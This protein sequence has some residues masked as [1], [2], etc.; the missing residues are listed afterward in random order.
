MTK[1][2]AE[3][4]YNSVGGFI[5][6]IF[7]D[8][9]SK[10]TKD[11]IGLVTD[12][13]SIAS[14]MTKRTLL[15]KFV[16]AVS[17]I[18]DMSV[19]YD[20]YTSETVT[21][22]KRTSDVLKLIS[23]AGALVI[24]F[25]PELGATELGLN[26]LGM[27]RNDVLLQSEGYK[28]ASDEK[29]DLKEMW[30]DFV[31]SMNDDADRDPYK[32]PERDP[33]KDPERDPYKDPERDPYKDPERDPYKDP[34]RDPHKD[35]GRDPHKDPE[36][37][38]YTPPWWWPFKP[39]DSEHVDPVVLNLKK[40]GGSRALEA[41]F[42][43]FDYDG[44]G[45]AE[46]TAWIGKNQGLL[47]IDRNGNETI[48]DGGELFGNQTILSNGRTAVDGYQ[49]LAELD[50]NH[51]GVIDATDAAWQDLRVWVD[52]GDGAT[53]E[54][55]LK[56]LDELGITSLS[57]QKS[58]ETSADS[59][60]NEKRLIGTFTWTDG[61]TG[62]MHDYLFAVDE[63][64]TYNKTS[65]AVSEEV[66][67]EFYLPGSG[68]LESSWQF[69]MKSEDDALQSLLHEYQAATDADATS[70][71]LD[72]ILYAMAGNTDDNAG[73]GSYMDARQLNVIEKFF[74]TKFNNGGNPNKWNGPL[75]ADLY[76]NIKRYY[77]GWLSAQTTAAEYISKI[78]L[79]LD[80]ETGKLCIDFT[81]VKSSLDEKITEDFEAGKA[82]LADFTN[83]I[84]AVGLSNLSE[85]DSMCQEFIA[86][87]DELAVAVYTTGRNII[88][89]TDGNDT[90]HDNSSNSIILGGV[91]NDKLTA[92]GSDVML[93]GGK[94]N[95]ELHGSRGD[96]PNDW[97]DTAGTGTVSYVWNAGDGNDTIINVSNLERAQ[98]T[99]GKSYLRYGVG[100][101][102]ESLEFIRDKDNIRI[103]Y[104]KTGEAI[105]IRNW[106]KDVAYKLTGI[107]FADG[108]YMDSKTLYE[109]ASAFPTTEGNDTL[110]GSS[111]A[112]TLDGGAGDDY[113]EGWYGD[114]VY[115]W[116]MGSGNDTIHN[117]AKS[118]WGNYVEMGADVLHVKDISKEEM[119]WKV[120][121]NNLIGTIMQTNERVVLENW[122]ANKV[123]RLDYVIFDDGT[124]LTNDE[125]DAMAQISNGTEEADTIRGGDTLDDIIYGK[126]GNDRLYGNSGNDTL[127]GGAGD[128]Y[129]EGWYGDDVY[130]WG[131]G[132]G[133][134]TIHN[135]AKNG[136]GDY[137]DMGADVL[138]VKDISKEEMSWKV[139]GNNLIGTIMQTNERVVLENWYANKVNR[140]DY[141]IFDD[142]TILTNDEIDAMAQISNGTEEADT[143]RGGDTL[144]D[145][146][147]GKS[148]NDRLY[149][150]SGNDTLDGG[151]GDDYLEGW[152]GDD[153]Y[154]WG[155][156]SG[157][158][159][160]HNAA[161]SS[162][163]N[164][165]EMGAD[166]LHVKDI[167]KEEMS[168]KVSGNNLIGTIMQTNERVVL[169]NWY[170]NKVNRLDYVIFDDGTILTNDEIDAMAQISNG[171]EE[172]DTIRGGDTLDDIIYGKSGNDRLYG[173][174]G[175][176][177]LDG[178]AGDDYLE[179][180][181]G[182][183]VYVWGM[184]SGNDTIHNA[185][186][187]GWGNY[188]DMGMD[189]IK[190]T[191]GT[192][193]ENVFWRRDKNDLLAT[194]SDTGEILRMQD[195]YKDSKNRIDRI[196]FSD[197]SIYTSD[198]IDHCVSTFQATVTGA[199]T[200][201]GV[202]LSHNI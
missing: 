102:A 7:S 88:Q 67:N 76:G 34:E 56:T 19:V 38:K 69:M 120:S 138:H 156:G 189:T 115:V 5:D 8:K 142:G 10:D 128:D 158:D 200:S 143:I 155:M 134:D 22:E 57:R 50:G 59:S 30:H 162:W 96:S 146:I 176:D 171:T 105:S 163:G 145:I 118:S 15:P 94:G 137:V 164:Y 44:D 77:E 86:E 24:D 116:G 1:D 106:F 180:W 20:D 197:S 65:V 135:T 95:D 36:R 3:R 184:G 144:D 26:F 64:N 52:N 157:N 159:T 183:D 87:N 193:T 130:V 98:K 100:I 62:E 191:D 51:D 104:V 152:Y 110:I 196:S 45:F 123:N 187:N 186:K 168:W 175:N 132:S 43:N 148:G 153:V 97:G 125:I 84:N 112:D 60:G 154:V 25:N 201:A 35:P 68:M 150:N 133:N 109:K 122:Y 2:M 129:L 92:H 160:I 99:S 202:I 161:K 173:N 185:A 124:I 66:A 181:Y 82:A 63:K 147:Y 93:V 46:Q 72:W 54:G 28:L 49:A 113:L 21:T 121:G 101:T 27:L 23:D 127:D 73:R 32:D 169:E 114:D 177:T 13:F 42:A 190:F 37:H 195:W 174:S 103:K 70:E 198:E 179:G 165:V 4:L 167:S 78:A 39:R 90:L 53:Q 81:D 40:D 17:L 9:Q 31:F 55:E 194:L 14:Y 79:A 126:S 48:D 178:G 41:S 74:G 11:Q 117:A 47:V 12:F 166:V 141:V 136:W 188:V 170:A 111:E 58:L 18:N 199:S 139:S 33:Y 182:D 192:L 91:G 108:S 149:G 71:L 80:D 6:L 61:T 151:A 89:G 83:A 172:A 16:D 107:I 119:S 85:Y 131:M 140:L 75:L 29:W